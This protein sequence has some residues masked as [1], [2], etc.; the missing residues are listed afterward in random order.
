MEADPQPTQI[1]DLPE[2][3]IGPG[4]AI[5]AL[6]LALIGLALLVA[7]AVT[8]RIVFSLRFPASAEKKADPVEAAR[9]RLAHLHQRLPELTAK[10]VA[11]ELPRIVK[12]YLRGKFGVN[13]AGATTAELWEDRAQWE[14]HLP[15]GFGEY[16]AHF[17]N[18]CD[19][20]KFEA[21]DPGEGTKQQLF[22]AAMFADLAEDGTWSLDRYARK[23]AISPTTPA[24]AE[25]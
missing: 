10:E 20:V 2:D 9:I 11:V 6:K 22:E 8:A 19:A 3:I 23:P 12:D 25:A 5:S 13:L 16:L 4:A 14:S 21:A 17:F 15:Q 24:T 18:Q 1:P 7:L